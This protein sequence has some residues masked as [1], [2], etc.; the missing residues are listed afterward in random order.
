M[1]GHRTALPSGDHDILRSSLLLI[2]CERFRRLRTDF[3]LIYLFFFCL[4]ITC[5]STSLFFPSLEI[6]TLSVPK[7]P[8][9]TL[10]DL[11][12]GY[13]CL[14]PFWG[15]RAGLWYQLGLYWGKD[16]VSFS[17]ITC[18]HLGENIPFLLMWELVLLFIVVVHLS[19]S[20]QWNYQVFIIS[21]CIFPILFT[22]VTSGKFHHIFFIVLMYYMFTIHQSVTGHLDLLYIR[23]IRK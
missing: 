4:V 6:P 16:S 10:L 12:A 14:L 11:F 2:F 18:F 13:S 3:K 19:P 20:W 9:D 22:H 15:P 17:Q 21:F 1:C 8:A 7:F 5:A 23:V